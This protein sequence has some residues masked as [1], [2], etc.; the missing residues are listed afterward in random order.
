MMV[1][2]F[3]YTPGLRINSNFYCQF[4]PLL[5]LRNLEIPNIINLLVLH[6][7]IFHSCKVFAVLRKKLYRL[8]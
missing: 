7:F 1:K 4:P 8:R 2:R 6:K 5:F 3:L